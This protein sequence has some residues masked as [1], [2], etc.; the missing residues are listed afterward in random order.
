M[1]KDSK[2]YVYVC[3]QCG[4]EFE[5]KTLAD[6][7]EKLCSRNKVNQSKDVVI[8][9]PKNIG[10]IL[11]AVL[12]LFGFVGL[13]KA[14]DYSHK[15][16]IQTMPII[17]NVSPTS[18]LIT[19]TPLIPQLNATVI[20]GLINDYRVSRGLSRL[21]WDE[22]MCQF[23][24]KR[25]KQIHTDHSHS[26]FTAEVGKTYC[27]QCRHAGENLAGDVW[28]NQELVQGWI[29]SPTHLD[30]ILQPD[31]K[32]TCIVTDTIGEHSFVVQEFSTNY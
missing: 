32:V 15:Q 26:G 4:E 2:Q 14:L 18:E 30:D 11:I 29:N 23:A 9:I 31:Y 19:P 10:A 13:V 20:F 28:S 6:T 1:K 12:I 16:S 25:L 7:H 22:N 17:V 21:E 8:K 27:K 3:E 5:K 24:I